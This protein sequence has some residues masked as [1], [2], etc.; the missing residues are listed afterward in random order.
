[1]KY[2][3]STRKFMTLLV[4]LWSTGSLFSQSNQY[5]HFDRVDDFV[6][7]PN[8]SQYIANSNAISMAGWFYTDELAYGQGMMGFR[9]GGTGNGEM[10][11]IQLN[12]GTIE[13]RFKNQSNTLYEFV[14]PA[15]TIQPQVWQHVAWVYNGSKIELFIDGVSIGSAAA[16]GTIT[17]TN[18]AFGIGKSI[19]GG[20]NF[21]FGGRVDEVS[22]WNK[23]LTPTDLQDMMQNELTGF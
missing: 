23:A 18:R 7:V 3:Y 14:A 5:L 2:H 6:E 1:M 9:G 15:F 8:A 4:V 20:F 19:Q 10:Y 17:S 16:S 13:C 12:N 11:L 22:L 21:V